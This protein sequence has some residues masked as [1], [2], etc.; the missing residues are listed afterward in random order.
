MIRDTGTLVEFWL[1]AGS[2]TFMHELPW[3]YTVNGTTDNSNTFD[4]QSGGAWQKIRSWT[5]STDQTVTFRLMATGT[6]GLGGP[7]NLSAAINRATAPPAPTKPVISGITNTS[8]TADTN[9]NGTGGAAIDLIQIGIGLSTSSAPTIIYTANSSGSYTVTGRVPG[10]PY[11]VWGRMH[12][13]EGY[14]PWSAYAVALTLD[15]PDAP[16]QP[17]LSNVTQSSVDVAFTDGANGGSPI[18]SREIGYHTDPAITMPLLIAS[19]G[20]TTV[21][22]LT[23][24]TV[25]YFWARTIN[26]YGPSPWSPV[27]STKTI[28]G[29]KV[30]V[31]GAPGVWHDA[32]PYVRV[33]GVW[34][35]ARP[36]GKVAGYWKETS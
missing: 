30:F 29:A 15:V 24:A 3:G 25:W 2:S 26:A 28:A 11:R 35:P 14:S 31:P 21:T 20:S 12:N 4:F 16:S 17:V 22:G 27:S 6:G 18:T 36:W 8:F 5:V 32:V 7:T 34:R 1:K 9:S 23:P 33:S 13:S 10:Y 19:D